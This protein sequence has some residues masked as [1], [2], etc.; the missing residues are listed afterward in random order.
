MAAANADKRT[1]I[2]AADQQARLREAPY[3]RLM[4][5]MDMQGRYGDGLLGT[6]G[7]GVTAPAY[8]SGGILGRTA[9]PPVSYGG[10]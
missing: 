3:D 4:K 5:M 10:R 7:A 8:G 6:P 9:L 1:Q 2:D